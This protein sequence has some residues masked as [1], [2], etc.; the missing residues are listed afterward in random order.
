MELYL[1]PSVTGDELTSRSLDRCVC[2]MQI[3]SVTQY[4][5]LLFLAVP[6]WRFTL[7]QNSRVTESQTA[8]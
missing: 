8:L 1:P 2:L 4:V 6:E 7:I 3:S 5:Y